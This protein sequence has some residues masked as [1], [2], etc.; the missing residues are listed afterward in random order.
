[1][2]TRAGVL[3][4]ML[5]AAGRA[6]PLLEEG[7]E[8]RERDEFRNGFIVGV[9]ARNRTIFVVI[10]LVCMGMLSFLLGKLLPVK[11]GDRS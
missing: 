11:C 2:T 8:L 5:A 4:L 3:V 6:A 9:P 1:M 10:A 7:A